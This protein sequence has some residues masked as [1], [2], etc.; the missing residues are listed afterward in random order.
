MMKACLPYLISKLSNGL[1]HLIYFLS[2]LVNLVVTLSRQQ[3]NVDSG[4]YIY[5]IHVIIF[6]SGK[7]SFLYHHH[8]TLH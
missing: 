6:Q 4:L 8:P 1:P 3:C 7:D 2:Q 5:N